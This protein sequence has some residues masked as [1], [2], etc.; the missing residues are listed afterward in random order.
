MAPMAAKDV[1]PVTA[2]EKKIAEAASRLTKT[3]EEAML[4]T[5]LPMIFL[6]FFQLLFQKG[7]ASGLQLAKGERPQDPL[8]AIRETIDS[9]LPDA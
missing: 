3:P 7:I 2:V 8:E 9:Y 4:A 6:G 5:R 1:D